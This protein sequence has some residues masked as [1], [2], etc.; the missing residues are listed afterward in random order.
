MG[1]Y[2]NPG[3]SIYLEIGYDQGLAVR[4]LLEDA[5][6]RN[7]RVCRDLPCKDRVVCGVWQEPW[8]DCRK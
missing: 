8:E 4:R 7:V 6:F 3:G 1:S 5:G 2:L